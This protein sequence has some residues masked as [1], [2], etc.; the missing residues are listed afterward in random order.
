MK[1]KLFVPFPGNKPLAVRHHGDN[2]VIPVASRKLSTVTRL[3][4]CVSSQIYGQYLRLICISAEWMKQQFPQSAEPSPTVNA[5]KSHYLHTENLR[6]VFR[7]SLHRSQYRDHSSAKRHQVI[8]NQAATG[9][10]R[11][12]EVSMSCMAHSELCFPPASMR[13]S[14]VP[15]SPSA[16]Q[17]C[18]C[19]NDCRVLPTETESGLPASLVVQTEKTEEKVVLNERY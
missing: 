12:T 3:K 4:F 2:S 18:G 16:R 15:G 13:C 17:L 10:C 8:C 6:G 11:N 7:K 1:N 5:C 14:E 19:R 9:A